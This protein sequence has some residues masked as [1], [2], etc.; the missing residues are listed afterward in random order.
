MSGESQFTKMLGICEPA[1]VAM[2]VYIL[3][4]AMHLSQNINTMKL[5]AP[6]IKFLVGIAIATV[7]S[8]ITLDVYCKTDH[9]TFAWVLAV[10]S[11]LGF[12]LLVSG[13]SYKEE[14]N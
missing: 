9:K 14:D 8:V 13:K 6:T 2:M 3:M 5:D 4:F 10:M 1:Q 12:L 11:V 7:T